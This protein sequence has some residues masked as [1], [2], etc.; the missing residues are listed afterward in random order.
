MYGLSKGMEASLDLQDFPS[1][2]KPE[3]ATTF[4]PLW[5]ST[6]TRSS[7]ARRT[8]MQHVPRVVGNTKSASDL[9]AAR[10]AISEALGVRSDAARF[11]AA[12]CAPQPEP[13]Q[14]G[15]ADPTVVVCP[16]AVGVAA[17][18]VVGTSSEATRRLRTAARTETN[19]SASTSELTLMVPASTLP[20][21]QSGFNSSA[22]L[23]H[24]HWLE[25]S[26]TVHNLK[27]VAPAA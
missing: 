24:D 20:A 11:H 22:P 14:S 17:G 8:P 16:A 21:L 25:I 6:R 10:A 15:R 2:T 23:V 18:G 5:P 26:C 9:S 13:L 7:T 1:A 4:E 27:L 19:S 3:R 12:S